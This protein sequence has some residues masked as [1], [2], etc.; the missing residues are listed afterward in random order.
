MNISITKVQGRVILEFLEQ[1]FTHYMP[2]SDKEK[3]VLDNLYTKLEKE[4]EA[5]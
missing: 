5:K 3:K 2:M 4:V 1:D